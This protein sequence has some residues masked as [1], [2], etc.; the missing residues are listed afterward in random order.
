MEYNDYYDMD[1]IRHIFEHTRIIKRP[2][3][4]IVSGEHK[5]PYVLV[6]ES[7]KHSTGTFEARGEIHVSP[8]M[9]WTPNYP[10]KTYGELF[11]E[12]DLPKGIMARTFGFL[13]FRG[14]PVEIQSEHLKSK[15]LR[16]NVEDAESR[17]LDELA[18][19]EDIET[20]VINSPDVRYFPVSLEKFISSILKDEFGIGRGPNS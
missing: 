4:G 19:K 17:I 20:G 12:E 10:S 1:L 11:G 7:L 18:R 5:V 8:R 15:E 2:T 13:S 9:V 3:Y 14:E 16:M 6:G